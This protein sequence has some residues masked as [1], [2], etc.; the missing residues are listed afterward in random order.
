MPTHPRRSL[1]RGT[2]PSA[3]EAPGLADV[4]AEVRLVRDGPVPVANCSHCG[5]RLRLSVVGD[6]WVVRRPRDVADRLSIQLGTLDREE[7]HVLLLD[8]RNVVL[9]QER[10]YQGNVSSAVARIGELFRGAVTRNAP[11]LILCHNHPSGDLE[12]SADDLRLTAEA[13]AAGRLLDIEVL[14]HVIVGATGYVSLRDAGLGFG[15]DHRSIAAT[16]DDR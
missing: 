1:A 9:D 5:S 8:T 12:P 7:L 6:R 4:G 13:I 11:R 3:A 14:D 2:S 16:G 10:V 15:G